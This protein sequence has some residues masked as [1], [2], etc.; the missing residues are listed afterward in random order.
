MFLGKLGAKGEAIRQ[1]GGR[2]RAK[3]NWVLRPLAHRSHIH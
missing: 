3:L 1:M 2:E